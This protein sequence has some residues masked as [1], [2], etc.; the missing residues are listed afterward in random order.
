MADLGAIEAVGSAF[1]VTSV[2]HQ[3]KRWFAREHFA[4][5]ITTQIAHYAQVH[6]YSPLAHCVMPDHY[7]LVL[8]IK[9]SSSLS[10]ILHSIHSYSVTLISRELGQMRKPKV[11]QGR[12][13]DRPLRTQKALRN[14]IAYVLL[15]PWR[16]GLVENPTDPFPHS[17]LGNWLKM[18]GKEYVLGLFEEYAGSMG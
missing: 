16:S 17:N 8:L 3:R 14:A 4:G 7:H 2:T 12:A 1:L 6:E 15:D 13:W 5:I 18:Q 10:Q 9:G 11:W